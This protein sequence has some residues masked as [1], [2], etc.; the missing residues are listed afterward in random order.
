[1]KLLYMDSGCLGAMPFAQDY[2]KRVLNYCKRTKTSHIFISGKTRDMNHTECFLRACKKADIQLVL[3]SGEY[4]LNEVKL[5]LYDN[6]LSIATLGSWKAQNGVVF[7]IDTENHF[8]QPIYMDLFL[9]HMSES[10]MEDLEEDLNK[11]MRE[12]FHACKKR[13]PFH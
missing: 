13:D 12:L 6:A 8:S 9:N 1:M 5:T 3:Q 11:L 7:A 4:E 2:Q 10:D